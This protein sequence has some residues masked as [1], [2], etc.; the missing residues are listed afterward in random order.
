MRRNVGGRLILELRRSE[1]T[2]SG[3]DV[4]DGTAIGTVGATGNVVGGIGNG[5]ADGANHPKWQMVAAGVDPRPVV[6]VVVGA[7]VGG[8]VMVRERDMGVH[9][10]PQEVVVA[11][12]EA[13]AMM[14]TVAVPATRV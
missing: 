11:T 2:G 1:G 7:M 14:G 3:E 5:V 10:L 6:G 12:L 4:R 9:T 8:Q 13:I